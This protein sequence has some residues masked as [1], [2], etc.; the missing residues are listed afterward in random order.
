MHKLTSFRH[1]YLKLFEIVTFGSGKS[2]LDFHLVYNECF[3]IWRPMQQKLQMVI[4]GQ[5]W[6]HFVYF[7]Y[8]KASMIFFDTICT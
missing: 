4:F 5:I 2:F 6:L 1:Q 3:K 7:W 8:L